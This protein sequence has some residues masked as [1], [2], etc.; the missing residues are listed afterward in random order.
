MA[1]VGSQAI[2][3]R[4][5]DVLLV[6]RPDDRAHRVSKWI[7]DATRSPYSHTIV[8]LEDGS[9]AQATAGQ[10]GASDVQ[11]LTQKDLERLI[12]CVVRIDLFR[13][14]DEFP[15][16][17]K[18]LL[19]SEV[20]RLF[21]LSQLQPGGS[22]DVM[23][24]MGAAA[25]MAALQAVQARLEDKTLEKDVRVD[26]ERWQDAFFW[27]LENGPSRLVCSEFAHVVLDIA[28]ERPRL[29]AKPALRTENWPTDEPGLTVLG[30]SHWFHEVGRKIGQRI[31]EQIFTDGDA[32][33]T[34]GEEWD[35]VKCAYDQG[36]R[37]QR[38]TIANFFTPADFSWS[39]TFLRTARRTKGSP[40]WQP[41]P[42]MPTDGSPV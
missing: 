27:A 30:L 36:L 7:R 21:R 33:R 14:K 6:E 29:P 20:E 37:P 35:R 10:D 16:A 25:S 42:P 17:D 5:G 32:L 28:G 24:S 31:G 41:A 38:L 11:M 19:T 9:Y 13:P 34:L 18:A 8:V 2:T 39:P 12:E 15:L 23:F 4:T 3:A 1:K 40:D 22:P 26:L